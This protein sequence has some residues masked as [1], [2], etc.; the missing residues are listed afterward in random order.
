MSNKFYKHLK[1]N[2]I[3]E[4]IKDNHDGT[5]LIL[6]L[7]HKYKINKGLLQF[8]GYNIKNNNKNDMRRGDK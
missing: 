4:E 5:A 6:Y 7:G 2:I 1:L 8:H 3:V